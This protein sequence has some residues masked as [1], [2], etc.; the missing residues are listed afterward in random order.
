MATLVSLNC[1]LI[2][3]GLRILT[4]MTCFTVAETCLQIG[5]V[6]KLSVTVADVGIMVSRVV[7]SGDSFIGQSK[8]AATEKVL[9][10]TTYKCKEIPEMLAKVPWMEECNGSDSELSN[11]DTSMM[12]TETPALTSGN[13]TS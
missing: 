12:D 7:L 1:G 13:V 10:Q 2:T 11:D 8:D 3:D 6:L 9:L 5:D 4:H